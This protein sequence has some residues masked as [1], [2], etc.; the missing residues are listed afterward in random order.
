MKPPCS[1]HVRYGRRGRHLLR[2]SGVLSKVVLSHHTLRN[3]GKQA[4]DLGG[5]DVYLLQAMDE[6]GSRHVQDKQQ[7]YLAR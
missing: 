2:L 1:V 6:T 3:R 7:A 5:D 4:L